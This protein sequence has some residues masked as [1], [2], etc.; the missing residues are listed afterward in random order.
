M[1]KSSLLF[2]AL[3]AF[4]ISA[5]AQ[6][7][8][9]NVFFKERVKQHAERL[10]SSDTDPCRLSEIPFSQQNATYAPL[11][12]AELLTTQAWNWEE[13]QLVDLPFEF[14]VNGFSSEQVL[15]AFEYMQAYISDD[16]TQH[17]LYFLPLYIDYVDWAFEN[18]QNE[19]SSPVYVK[20][21][22]NAGS[23]IIILEF[24]NIGLFFDD[25]ERDFV[26]FQLWLYEDSN[27]IEYHYG[28]YQIADPTAVFEFD[29][30]PIV[31]ILCEDLDSGSVTALTLAGDPL[32]PE[33][34]LYSEDYDIEENGPF[35]LSGMPPSGTVYRFNDQN[36][37]IRN[38]SDLSL[39]FV[40]S[41]NPFSSQL[42]IRANEELPANTDFVLF[43]AEGKMVLQ[44]PLPQ[45]SEHILTT[46][47]LG[48]G[49]FYYVLRNNSQILHSGV[50]IK[51][52]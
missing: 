17:I 11:T 41:P 8:K 43:D 39:N 18:G 15:L 50:V 48:L 36:V 27:T 42:S 4:T 7:K 21:L 19:S 46:D 44:A 9:S 26:N 2:L 14:T 33:L 37:S 13:E 31:A 25:N 12:G 30:G 5:F 38:H 29:D 23:Q 47:N 3:V 32:N 45:G 52:Q 35:W 34:V 16:R 51:A 40:L 10:R 1:K 6:S 28:D 49:T 22:G 20:T 24:K